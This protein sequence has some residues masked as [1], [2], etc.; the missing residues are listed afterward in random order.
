MKLCVKERRLLIYRKSPLEPSL[1]LVTR[2]GT[3]TH[4]FITPKSSRPATKAARYMAGNSPSSRSGV[5]DPAF[6]LHLRSRAEPICAREIGSAGSPG[7]YHQPWDPL[8]ITTL[9]QSSLCHRFVRFLRCFYCH[10]RP[11]CL[12][13]SL[14][15][16][17]TPPSP[18]P[19]SFL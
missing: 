10:P 17:R 3:G 1:R 5:H 12:S 13:F 9:P 2:V 7:T 14:L 19:P 11:I 18:H 16:F 15:T 6:C 4:F 8:S